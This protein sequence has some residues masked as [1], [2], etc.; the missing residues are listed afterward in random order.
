[1]T[2]VPP[3]AIEKAAH[4]IGKSERAI[5]DAR[6]RAGAPVER[7]RELPGGDQLSRWLPAISAAKARAA[8]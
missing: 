6:P 4:W 7:R 3:E 8:P 1:M 2:G 5:A